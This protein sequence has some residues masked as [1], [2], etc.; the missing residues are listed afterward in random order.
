MTHG[1]H[2]QARTCTK[3][4]HGQ[5]E[6]REKVQQSHG[7][8]SDRLGLLALGNTAAERCRSLLEISSLRTPD[9]SKASFTNWLSLYC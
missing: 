5:E 9:M 6:R 7:W 1:F 3:G 4:G 8:E 2:T